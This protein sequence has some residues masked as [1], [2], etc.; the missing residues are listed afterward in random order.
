LEH[1]E[2]D[3]QKKQDE[4]AT[5]PAKKEKR[6]RQAERLRTHITTL[7]KEKEK[8]TGEKVAF[9]EENRLLQER[10]KYLEDLHL[11][12]SPE[13][14]QLRDANQRMRSYLE[15]LKRRIADGGGAEDGDFPGVGDGG[16]SSD[17]RRLNPH[18]RPRSAQSPGGR[19][20]GDERGRGRGVGGRGTRKGESRMGAS[21]RR[22]LEDVQEEE[23]YEEEEDRME[24]EAEEE[25]EEEE[26]ME[27]ST[28]KREA[29]EYGGDEE[30]VSD[31]QLS[32]ADG[33]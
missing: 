14:V 8:L 10:T 18:Q 11:D 9:E 13:F 7:L 4:I 6:E 26:R 30:D 29:S 15:Q 2:A 3:F 21:K 31:Q 32:G 27:L 5:L 17:S 12:E 19:S 16:G 23:E 22:R 1:F 33:E 28:Q 25:E 20:R 24:E